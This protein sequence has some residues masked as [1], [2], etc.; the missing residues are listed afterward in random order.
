MISIFKILIS[1]LL[2]KLLNSIKDM[3]CTNT[4]KDLNKEQVKDPH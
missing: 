3:V 2:K 4:L 1:I